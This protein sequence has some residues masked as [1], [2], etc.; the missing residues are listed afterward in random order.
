MHIG[1]GFDRDLDVPAL[2]ERYPDRRTHLEYAL[3]TNQRGQALIEQLRGWGVS[4]ESAARQSKAYLDIGFAYGGC[5]AS[6]AQLGF[7]VTGIEIDEKYGRL[8][9]WN[10]ESFGQGIDTRIGDF[11]AEEVLPAGARFDIITCTDV[12]EHVADPEASMHKICRLLKPGGVAYIAY[13]TKL[14]I[15]YVRADAHF[16]LF[17]LT[18][19]DYFRA[20]AAHAMYTGRPEYEVSDFYEPEWY[21]NTARSAG[22]SA[23]LVYD[24]AMQPPD[25]AGEIAQLQAAYAEWTRSAAKKLDPL[26]RHEITREFALYSARLFQDY[27]HHIAQNSVDQFARRWLDPLTRILIRKP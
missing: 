13:P 11:Q 17:G 7:A 18:L 9:R 5:L 2:L 6:F 10:L 14:C 3:T 27:S 8:G 1:I 23:E 4:V 26:M 20:R 15:S 22:V 25:V 19:L 16:G 21:L 12:I 24:S